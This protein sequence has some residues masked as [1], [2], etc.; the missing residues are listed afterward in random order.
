MSDPNF[1]GPEEM[2]RRLQAFLQ[3]AFQ[4]Q[5]RPEAAEP[6]GA[7]EETPAE[8]DNI[9]DFCLTH[10]EIKEHLDRFG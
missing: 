10:R 5:G 9:F 3:S 4:Q 7:P 8:E 2:Q 1:P 6:A